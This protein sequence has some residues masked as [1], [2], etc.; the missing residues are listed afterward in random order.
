MS[1]CMDVSLKGDSGRLVSATI[2][3]AP[4][5]ETE[6]PAVYLLLAAI[7]ELSSSLNRQDGL[8]ELDPPVL[9]RGTLIS[10]AIRAW[11]APPAV[12]IDEYD[13]AAHLARKYPEFQH[14]R[15]AISLVLS[16]ELPESLLLG[17]ESKF[18]RLNFSVYTPVG[19]PKDTAWGRWL[20][21]L[22]AWGKACFL[23]G[24]LEDE[25]V[26]LSAET[27][28]ISQVGFMVRL[29]V[30]N[31]PDGDLEQRES[32][33]TWRW[34]TDPID[35]TFPFAEN[36]SCACILLRVPE[37][38]V[39][40]N[41]LHALDLS[42]SGQP[43]QCPRAIISDGS[44][45]FY[46]VANL[47]EVSGRLVAASIVGQYV[48]ERVVPA[49]VLLHAVIAEVSS[50]FHRPVHAPQILG[51][52]NYA[53]PEVHSDLQ[54][55]RDFD[56]Y[57]LGRDREYFAA[58][59]DW[60]RAAFSSALDSLPIRGTVLTLHRTEPVPRR[61]TPWRCYDPYKPVPLPEDISQSVC[62]VQRG[63]NPTLGDLLKHNS[64]PLAFQIAAVL[65]R[66]A[67]KIGQGAWQQVYVGRLDGVDGLLCLK[68]FDER[69][70]QVPDL[71][72]F[73]QRKRLPDGQISIDQLVIKNIKVV[74]ER[75]RMQLQLGLPDERS[76][77]E[78]IHPADS[79]LRREEAAYSRLHE[80]QGGVVPHFY[81]CVEVELPG[82]HI[83]PAFVTEYVEGVPLPLLLDAVR[84][85]WTREE[86]VKL[87][88]RI[89]RCVRVLKASHMS[90]DSKRPSIQFLCLLRSDAAD[91]ADAVDLVVNNFPFTIQPWT[92]KD[93][94]PE[95]DDVR[96]LASELDL[97]DD[98]MAEAGWLPE[99]RRG[100]E[101]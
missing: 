14:V 8:Q 41:E 73:D 99:Q 20:S 56:A 17:L 43:F 26:G 21:L 78:D 81:G 83:A 90:T 63:R 48:P 69:L 4:V 49:M 19:Q 71:N 72:N 30:S 97:S 42:A 36:K 82:G 57:H 89:R 67:E 61:L 24:D 12:E 45:S 33:R 53:V 3:G 46:M 98:I 50:S 10:D 70:F 76:V 39:D 86:Q 47:V 44:M 84:N 95:T 11:G 6:C 27:R 93:I 88:T 16:P 85:T 75:G 32:A 2:T 87:F 29:V 100:Y 79:L 38:K 28:I 7:S 37:G 18:A 9:P 74:G 59:L 52:L 5:Q 96:R 51:A 54:G 15:A 22:G 62:S 13:P 58:F 31:I 101:M 68:V 23:P 64:A 65:T 25:N 94:F 55:F 92:S 77:L 35:N 91:R 60:K 1:F 66:G 34:Q 80:Y 40:W